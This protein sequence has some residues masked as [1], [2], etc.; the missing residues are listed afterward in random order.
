[1]SKVMKRGRKK[2]ILWFEVKELEQRQQKL[3]ENLGVE[4]IDIA[5]ISSWES[6]YYYLGIIT[7]QSRSRVVDPMPFI[8]GERDSNKITF[9]PTAQFDSTITLEHGYIPEHISYFDTHPWKEVS[10]KIADLGLETG[11]VGVDF[12]SFSAYHLELL[13]KLLPRVTFVDCT[14][15][16]EK[17]RMIKSPT[18]LEYFRRACLSAAKVLEQAPDIIQVGKTEL[19]VS[20]DI[21]RIIIENG[22]EAPAFHPQVASS[23]RSGLL[24]IAASDKKIE[25]GD[26]VMID[27]GASYRYYS[28][29]VA[30]PFVVGR[31]LTEEEN[32]AACAA[33]KITAAALDVVRADIPVN[34]IHRAAL[35]EAKQLGYEK[36]LKHGS[37]H[38]IGIYFWEPPALILSDNTI[39]RPGMTL[40]VEQGV[41]LPKF[42]FRFE[43]NLVVTKGGYEGLFS[44]PMEALQI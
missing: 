38:G 16:I 19:E 42:G 44:Y 43:Q 37:G 13:K 15:I 3:M 1:M 31:S 27:F 14:K 33:A 41:Y 30:R 21:I 40:A 12:R 34:E 35:E 26:I 18:E 36:Y 7:L 29:D 4:G 39:I 32:K 22:A 28:S 10:R 2:A 9:F 17:Q 11:K 24:N 25:N 6:L 23:Y 8:V 5:I 20:R